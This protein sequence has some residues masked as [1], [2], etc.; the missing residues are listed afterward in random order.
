MFALS[1]RTAGMCWRQI[2]SKIVKDTFYLKKAELFSN[3]KVLHQQYLWVEIFIL[4]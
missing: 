4:N 3:F 1:E 2:M